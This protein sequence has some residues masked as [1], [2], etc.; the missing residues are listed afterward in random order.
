MASLIYTRRPFRPGEQYN[1]NKVHEDIKYSAED[2]KAIDDWISGRFQARGYET[3]SVDI[4]ALQTTLRLPG[5][6]SVSL[7][8]F[9]PVWRIETD[10]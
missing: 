2:D 9:L 4:N 3:T 6:V 5:T 7:V 8:A 10:M 1:A